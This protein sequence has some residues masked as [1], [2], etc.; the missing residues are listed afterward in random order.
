MPE[1]GADCNNW[2]QR[3]QHSKWS[4]RAYAYQEVACHVYTLRQPQGEGEGEG[5]GK[6]SA[7]S[8]AEYEGAVRKGLMEESN[9]NALD[10]A[11]NA[12]LQ[13]LQYAPLPAC[14]ELCAQAAPVLVSK[15]LALPRVGGKV[16]EVLLQMIEAEAAPLVI[17]QLV[18]GM[19]S[20][21]AKQA[22]AAALVAT[23][24]VRQFG[25]GQSLARQSLATA[26]VAL[27]ESSTGAVRAQALLLAREL[28]L[29]LGHG[30]RPLFDSLRPIQALC[31]SSASPHTST[32][33]F[34]CPRS[35]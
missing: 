5:E 1:E 19:R 14:Q 7:G 22:A 34:S 12:A 23:E 25:G 27:F 18:Q 29:A 35:P 15:A 6:G 2:Q 24:A 32:H 4:V 20:R 16:Q 10:K 8:W 30:I 26:C 13:L 9:V 3:L 21:N 11:L 17:P 33:T 28:F 31:P